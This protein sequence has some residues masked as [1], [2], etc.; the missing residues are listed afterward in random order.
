MLHVPCVLI[1]SSSVPSLEDRQVIQA[2]LVHFVVR[3]A[4]LGLCLRN[5][6]RFET[7]RDGR[8]GPTPL[9]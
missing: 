5:N 2:L 4:V 3:T 1:L 7:S 9:Q 6:D 8:V